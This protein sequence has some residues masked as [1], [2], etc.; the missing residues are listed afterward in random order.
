MAT[1]RKILIAD[2]DLEAVR[3]LTRVL[4]QRGYTVHYAQD[5]SRAL[6][7]AVLRHPDV[8]LFDEHCRLLDARTFVQILRTNPRTQAIPV[9]LTARAVDEA[10]LRGLRDGYLKKPFNVD[11][12][13]SRVEHLVRRSD[14]AQN[15]RGETQVL[16]GSLAQLGIPDLL[17][18][19]AMHRRS[20][21]LQLARGDERGDIYVGE[22]RPVLARAGRVEGEK[23]L[24]RVLTWTDGTFSFAPGPPPS[25][26]ERITRSMDDALLEGM[27]QADE[28]A[29]LE[30]SLPPRHFHL[31]LLP[32]A[33]LKGAQHPVTECVVE[34]LRQSRALQDVVDLTPASDLDVLG[35]VATLLSKGVARVLEEAPEVRGPEPLLGAADAHALRTRALK[36][37]SS[38]PSVA[39]AK[40]LLCGGPA[41][42]RAFLDQVPALERLGPESGAARSGF[43]TLAHLEVS[44]ALRVDVCTLPPQE[45]SRPLW[46]PFGVGAVGALLL[47]PEDG[48]V[49]QARHLALEARLPVVSVGPSLPEGLHGAPGGA[50]VVAESAVEALRA[51]LL[52]S[53]RPP[54]P[55]VGLALQPLSAAS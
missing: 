26:G 4:R 37:R 54:R 44:E 11:E 55:V 33:D 17:Q 34:L 38:T 14:A 35:V 7:V 50:Q 39:V 42:V 12:V 29:R 47:E 53:L 19:L 2:P 18:V 36:G 51:V 21:R 40:V 45:A 5:S 16:E 27:R 3:S 13:L 10:A 25:G 46:S 24:F 15:L 8:V 9:L 49:R 32:D 23:A 1:T 30:S 6:E 48:A 43:G 22:G 28:V 20:G 31:Q 41:A 52:L